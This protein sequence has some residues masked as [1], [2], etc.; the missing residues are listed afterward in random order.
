MVVADGMQAE[1]RL[2]EEE[3]HLLPLRPQLLHKQK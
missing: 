3:G 1:L 2:M